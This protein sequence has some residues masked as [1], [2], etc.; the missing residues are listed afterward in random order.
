MMANIA[1]GESSWNPRAQNPLAVNGLHAQGLWQILGKPFPGNA[2]DPLT[3]AR[4]AVAKWRSGGIHPWDASA[5]VWSQ[6]NS[7][8]AH[9][10][11][12]RIPGFGGWFAKG[13][14]MRV[15]GPLAIGVGD[16]QPSGGSEEVSVRR[17]RPGD[18]GGHGGA[19]VS[20]KVDMGGVTIQGGDSGDAERLADSVAEVVARKLDEALRRNS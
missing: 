11:G 13:G 3:N 10:L 20:V 2:F 14:H 15:R 4:M 5:G 9:A 18:H 16:G 6:R 19:Q 7:A 12:G 8:P 1:W 17:V